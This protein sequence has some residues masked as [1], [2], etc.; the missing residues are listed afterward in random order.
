MS[1]LY[2]CIYDPKQTQ[3]GFSLKYFPRHALSENLQRMIKKTRI[4]HLGQETVV[5]WCDESQTH[6]NY[7]GD[8]YEITWQNNAI[9]TETEWLNMSEIRLE[10]RETNLHG[11]VAI[12]SKI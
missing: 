8:L 4:V 10:L 3:I 5:R 11:K 7:G 1:S 9:P 12:L 6:I 2:N